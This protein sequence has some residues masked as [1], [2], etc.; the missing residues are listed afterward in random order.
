MQPRPPDEDPARR[1]RSR[2]EEFLAFVEE[3]RDGW[4]V[5]FQEMASS[6]PIA[7]Q[8]AALRAQIADGIRRLLE[9]GAPSECSLPVPAADAIAHAVVGA[10]ESFANWWLEHPEVSRRQVAD[11][12]VGVVQAALT[13]SARPVAN[14]A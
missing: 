2:I 4:I 8:V 5:L 6:R 1:L 14:D 3:H 10:G 7:E 12:Y 13:A 11:W 9:S